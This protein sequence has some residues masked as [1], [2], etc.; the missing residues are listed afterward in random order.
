MLHWIASTVGSLGYFGVGL[1][2]AIENVFLPLPSELIMPLAG[3][4][5]NHGGKTLLGVI[6]AGTIG[7]VAG[8]YPLFAVAWIFGPERV[9]KWAD[10]HGKW[11]LLRRGDLERAHDQFEKRGTMAVFISQLIPGLRGLISIPAGFAHMN[12]LLF[13][14]ANFAGTIIWCAVLAFLGHELDAHFARIHKTL[15]PVGWAILAAVVVGGV[16]WLYI[17]KRRKGRKLARG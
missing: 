17:R 4:W 12:V 7:G 13:T 9:T 11:L 2:M 10:R 5:T 8:A 1:L 3:A 6:I 14:A 16:V 15:G